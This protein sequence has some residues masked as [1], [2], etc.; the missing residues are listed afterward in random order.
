MDP[1]F[2]GEIFWASIYSHVDGCEGSFYY[3][4][5]KQESA[6]EHFAPLLEGIAGE[7][8]WV[9]FGNWLAI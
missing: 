8:K 9:Y 6:G 2:Q 4:L 7:G 5:W 1:F 3:F